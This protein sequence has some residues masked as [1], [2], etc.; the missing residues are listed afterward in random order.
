MAR[1]T[2]KLKLGDKVEAGSFS[3]TVFQRVPVI[4]QSEKR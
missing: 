2:L 3:V 4:G 1:K